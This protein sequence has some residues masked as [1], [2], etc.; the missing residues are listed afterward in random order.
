[1]FDSRLKPIGCDC[2]VMVTLLA[3]TFIVLIVP[4][5]RGYPS[6]LAAAVYSAIS[7]TSARVHWNTLTALHSLCCGL[8]R[9]SIVEWTFFYMVGAINTTAFGFDRTRMAAHSLSYSE[10]PGL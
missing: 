9:S 5:P 8:M 7:M 2:T 6:V 4:G 10:I 1:V 3:A